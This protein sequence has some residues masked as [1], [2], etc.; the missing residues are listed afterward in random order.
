MKSLDEPLKFPFPFSYQKGFCTTRQRHEAY[1]NR[2]TRRKQGLPSEKGSWLQ[3]IFTSELCIG[4]RSSKLFSEEIIHL[5]N[6]LEL[7]LGR[8]ITLNKVKSPPPPPLPSD[9][10]R[11]VPFCCLLL[12]HEIQIYQPKWVITINKGVPMP[13]WKWTSIQFLNT[14]L[15]F[16]NIVAHSPTLPWE[17]K[18]CCGNCLL[19]AR[20]NQINEGA[21]EK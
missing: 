21:P 4:E 9:S 15:T 1:K 14:L 17:Y 16:I 10:C 2:L 6:H 20:S 5:S 3:F 18:H 7:G 12:L 13:W 8:W 11:V 19:F